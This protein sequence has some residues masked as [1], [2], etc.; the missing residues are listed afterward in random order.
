MTVSTN[1]IAITVETACKRYR[2]FDRPRDRLLQM[3]RPRHIY[4]REFWA[5]RNI[6]F[7]IPRGETFG[8][9]GRN[10]A[11][12]STLLQLICGTLAPTSG[13]VRVNGRVA[14]LLE[15][16]AG[17]NPE[18]TGRENAILYGMVLGLSRAA[19]ADRIEKILA[20]ADIGKFIDQPIKTYSTGMIVRLAF[21]VIAHV[22][23]D[24]LVIDEALAVGDAI[25]TQK[26]M[27]FLR[28]FQERGTILFVSHD[29]TA[30]M[31]L[32]RQAIW[33]DHGE[34]R[35]AGTAK[36]VSESYLAYCMVPRADDTERPHTSADQ[37]EVGL[38]S[39]ASLAAPTQS[40][41]AR[42]AE[43]ER[44]GMDDDSGGFGQ[45]DAE[46]LSVKL[47][48]KD[49]H[50]ITAV[51]GGEAVALHIR[52]LAKKS[53]TRPIVGFLIK[54]RLGQF[55]FGDNTFLTYRDRE[56]PVDSGG[57]VEVQF[58]FDMPYLMGGDYSICV[59]LAEGTQEEHVIQ[60]WIHDALIFTSL[61]RHGVRGLV[62]IEMRRIELAT[63]AGRADL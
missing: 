8:I 6:S 54:D 30:V 5:L 43:T 32:C 31:G 52:C 12:K 35:K 51:E 46:I 61:T 28:N 38:D 15:L 44:F 36:E 53:M 37:A 24:I 55:L 17:F 20:F 4:F 63:E 48:G 42:G 7:E 11:G 50:N 19:M 29:I 16:G 49:G 23:A 9:I 22:D 18:F 13:S 1:D 10:G 60:H 39:P 40:R 21:A 33:L 27:R 25:F 62:G 56:T 58:A 26:C 41:N 45:G 34:V 47:V 3:W 14:A 57:T 2:I 59:G